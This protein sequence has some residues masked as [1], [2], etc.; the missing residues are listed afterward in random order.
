MERI[1]LTGTTKAIAHHA[2]IVGFWKD[3][4]LN[5]NKTYRSPKSKKATLERLKLMGDNII[6]RD[7]SVVKNKDGRHKFDRIKTHRHSLRSHKM[8][9]AC[10]NKA[11]VR[12]HIIWIKHGGL[13]SKRNLVSLC[14]PCHGFIHPWLLPNTQPHT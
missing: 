1:D 11:D 13:N 10:G 8:C 3:F 6:F 14:H 4:G 2:F 9:F 12:H 7:N 5:G